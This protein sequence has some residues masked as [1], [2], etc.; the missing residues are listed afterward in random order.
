MHL[1]KKILKDEAGAIRI[2]Y[3]MQKTPKKSLELLLDFLIICIYAVI[4]FGLSNAI[5]MFQ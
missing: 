5:F 3:T 1:S 2:G 4:T